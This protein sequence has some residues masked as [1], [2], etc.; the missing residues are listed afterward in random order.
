VCPS[1]EWGPVAS[2]AW[3]SHVHVAFVSLC[4]DK[5]ECVLAHMDERVYGFSALWQPLFDFQW[6]MW[7]RCARILVV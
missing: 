6:V 3:R 2:A 7:W 5:F 1:Q 4:V